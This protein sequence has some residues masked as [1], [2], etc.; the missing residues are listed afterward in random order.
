M[1]K[2]MMISAVAMSLVLGF[3]TSVMAAGSTIQSSTLRNDARVQN[4]TNIASGGFLGSA[5]A[6]QATL[7]VKDSTVRSSTILNRATVTNSTN[8]ASGG[9]L[10]SAEANQASIVVE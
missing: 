4:S 1:K 9:F 2:E 5:E 6:N 7:K 3:S 10:G 8:R